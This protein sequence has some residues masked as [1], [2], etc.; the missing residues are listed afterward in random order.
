[1]LMIIES[2]GKTVAR[3]EDW[4]GPIPRVGEWFIHPAFSATPGVDYS[5]QTAAR[6]DTAGCVRQ[7]LWGIYARPVNGEE[8][9]VPS[10]HPFVMVT[11]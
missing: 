2:D 1:M 8:H 4:D 3:L 6:Y 11:I 7:V 9:F 10:H 5:D